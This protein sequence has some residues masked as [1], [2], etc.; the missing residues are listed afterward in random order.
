MG[1]TLKS[2]GVVLALFSCIFIKSLVFALLIP[3]WLGNDEPN[4]FEYVLNMAKGGDFADG[5]KLIIASLNE[6]SF[7]K[8]AEMSP[9]PPGAAKFDDTDLRNHSEKMV[10]TRPPMYYLLAAAPLKAVYSDSMRL[11]LLMS[12]MVSVAIS[13]V[14]LLFVYLSARIFFGGVGGE[15]GAAGTL[16]VAGFH[17]Q[18]SYLSAVVNSDVLLTMWFSVFF[19]YSL[20]LLR[21]GGFGPVDLAVL[22]GVAACAALTKKQGLLLAPAL[23]LSVPFFVSGTGWREKAVG[24]LKAY[25]ALLGMTALFA[26]VAEAVFARNVVRLAD[27]SAL[28]LG[29]SFSTYI[30]FAGMTAMMWLKSLS[31]L[32]VTSWFTFGQMVHKQSYGFYLLYGAGSAVALYGLAR[33]FADAFRGAEGDDPART[34]MLALAG[35]TCALLAAVT[36]MIFASPTIYERISGRYLFYGVAPFSLLFYF[37]FSR[38]GPRGGVW[39]WTPAYGFISL[40]LIS[41]FGYL[42][43]L[44]YGK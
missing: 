21:K 3:P 38:L 20:R 16:A 7:W 42:L 22:L 15:A 6:T 9:P 36:L 23:L 28:N 25:A 41:I 18:F 24:S 31:I 12:R 35:M 8:N 34:R 39:E 33:H 40:N 14:T 19:Y 26:L 30:D 43:P 44:Y 32:F 27:I 11:N 17:P 10:D 4:H 5:Q 37:G 1:K 13:M 2:G 29:L